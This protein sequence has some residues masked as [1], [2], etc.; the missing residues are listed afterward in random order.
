MNN[1]ARHARATRV[2]LRLRVEGEA[3]RLALTDDGQGFAPAD[4]PAADG[5][6]AGYGLAGMRDRAAAIGAALDIHSAPGAGTEVSLV[7]PLGAP[8]AHAEAALSAEV[9]SQLHQAGV[10]HSVALGATLLGAAVAQSFIP[11]LAGGSQPPLAWLFSA[12]LLVACA[13][14]GRIAWARSQ[15]AALAVHLA[16]GA[17]SPTAWRMRRE[18]AAARLWA[19]LVAIVLLPGALMPKSWP[20]YPIAALAVGAACAACAA[21]VLAQSCRATEGYWGKLSATALAAELDG[22]WRQRYSWSL[23]VLVIAVGYFGLYGGFR[24]PFAWP[25][26]RDLVLDILTTLFINL[27]LVMTFVNYVQLRRWREQAGANASGV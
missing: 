20:Q 13:V 15:R 5:P 10:W 9:K 21:V 11:R 16:C 14:A 6:A 2:T 3:L 26:S 25:P 23:V 12:A 7:V 18:T 1:I 19:A 24:A 4:A 22:A 8:A 27:V 17:D